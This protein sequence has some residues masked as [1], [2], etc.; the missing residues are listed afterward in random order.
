MKT[1]LIATAACFAAQIA[2]N[3]QLAQA[4][5]SATATTAPTPVAGTET[6]YSVVQRD[7]NSRVWRKFHYESTPSGDVFA[8]P[9]Q[10]TELATGMHFIRNGQ[11]VET[12]EQIQLLPSGVGAAAT[13][14]PH[15]AF[16]PADLS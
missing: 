5:T 4:N 2:S 16:F 14:G 15:L 1:T 13:N 12:T 8:Q 7:A 6:P 10:Y 9:H 11:W 3:A